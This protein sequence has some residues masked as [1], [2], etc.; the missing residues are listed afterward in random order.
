[1]SQIANSKTGLA[2]YK[3]S[4]WMVN[5]YNGRLTCKGPGYGPWGSRDVTVAHS[6]YDF[7]TAGSSKGPGILYQLK[8]SCNAV[9]LNYNTGASLAGGRA[10]NEIPTKVIAEPHQYGVVFY[11]V[12][13]NGKSLRVEIDGWGHLKVK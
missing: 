6:V 2:R 7:W 13:Q 5:L 3:R 10:C 9:P 8:N 4:T 11:V 1:M 12:L